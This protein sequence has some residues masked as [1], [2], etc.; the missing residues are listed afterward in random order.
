MENGR[1][2]EIVSASWG[3]NGKLSG[4]NFHLNLSNEEQGQ[5]RAFPA[6]KAALADLQRDAY[7]HGDLSVLRPHWSAGPLVL[8]NHFPV[9]QK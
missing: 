8:R 7:T 9:L 2:A 3:S 6:E 5:R 1:C 4:N